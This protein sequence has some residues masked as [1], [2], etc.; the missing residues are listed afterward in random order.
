MLFAARVETESVTRNTKITAIVQRIVSN[1]LL[2][3]SDFT[4]IRSHKLILFWLQTIKS[5]F[6][7]NTHLSCYTFIRD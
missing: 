4:P 7:M 1:W 5:V 3:L 2:G 6:E